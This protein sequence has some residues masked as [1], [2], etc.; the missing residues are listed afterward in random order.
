MKNTPFKTVQSKGFT[1]LEVL[2]GITLLT[3]ILG[4]VY[5]SFFTANRAIERWT[6]T[7]IKYHDSRSALD[8]MR[9]EIEGAVLKTSPGSVNDMHKTAFVIED[10]DILGKTTSKLHLTAFSSRDSG[11]TNV[12]YY[13]REK[14]HGLTLVKAVSPF[15]AQLTDETEQQEKK[16]E[17]EV[18]S[19]IDSFAVETLFN[20]EWVKTW[21]TEQSGVLPEIVRISIVLDDKGSK[22]KLTEY[23]RPK[24]GKQI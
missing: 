17:F 23:A 22:V 15:S 9:R 13:V 24:I 7:T 2:L 19:G 14:E 6:G 8:I 16:H 5:T 11:V 1:L 4:A 12:S 10:R 3:I 20:N 18:I 21:H